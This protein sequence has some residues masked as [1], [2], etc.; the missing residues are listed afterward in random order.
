MIEQ[1]PIENIR[2]YGS[3]KDSGESRLKLLK[4]DVGFRMD[5]KAE[6]VIIGG[7][8]QP[9]AMPEVFRAFKNLL[10]NLNINYTLLS[11]EYCC[12]WIPIGQ[13]AVMTKNEEDIAQYKAISRDFIL[14]NFK[15]AEDLGAKSIVLFC[16][17][18]EPNYSNH[19]NAT[20]LDVIPYTELLDRSM[21]KGSLNTEIDYYAGCYRFRRRITKELLDTEPAERLLA[22]IEGL[23]TNKIDNDL[24]CYRQPDL[25]KIMGTLK[26]KTLMTICTGCYYNLK[27]NLQSKGDYQVKMLPE[28]LLESLS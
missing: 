14:E 12:G 17:A 6:Y 21:L 15:Q 26:T 19:K 20:Q 24:C 3:F 5:Q 1:K 7:C 13:M 10:E 25:E 22:K 23:K 4:E 2:Q 18:C 11:K 16:S 9:E 28:I 27:G 8:V